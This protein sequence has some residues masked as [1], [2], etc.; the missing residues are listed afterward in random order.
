[1]TVRTTGNET[2]VKTS[3]GAMYSLGNANY[4]AA[5]GRNITTCELGAQQE[6]REKSEDS[7]ESST[8]DSSKPG[9]PPCTEV[10]ESNTHTTHTNDGP[11]VNFR[12]LTINSI[13]VLL[14]KAVA[15]DILVT[16]KAMFF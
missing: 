8:Q 16:V 2:K 4:F 10:D 15:F 11:K 7:A 5:F 3:E 1:M 13:R 14:A 12:T 9:P 6:H